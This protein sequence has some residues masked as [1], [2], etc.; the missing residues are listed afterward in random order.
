MP[1]A[2]HEATVTDG[3][4]AAFVVTTSVGGGPDGVC[5]V[6]RVG[7]D[8]RMPWGAA[9]VELAGPG[10][11]SGRA[12]LARGVLVVAASSRDRGRVFVRES[13]GDPIGPAAGHPVTLTDGVEPA[14]AAV[15][16]QHERVLSLWHVV[17]PGRPWDVDVV[18]EIREMLPPP[19]RTPRGRV[20]APAPGARA[21]D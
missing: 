4:G 15:S 9:G 6:T 2:R 1:S 11:R 12:G 18:G 3:F 19:P 5:R 7:P 10:C 16:L 14:G 8:G 13:G 20:P 17:P 21:A